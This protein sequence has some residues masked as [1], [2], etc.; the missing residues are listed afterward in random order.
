[1]ESLI[2]RAL[3][4]WEAP[5][6]ARRAALERAHADPGIPNRA[7][8]TKSF[9]M[10]DEHPTINT[11]HGGNGVSHIDVAIVGSGITGL[12]VAHTLF[13]E[14]EAGERAALS[15][16]MLEAR[17]VCSGATGR[18][19]GHLLETVAE[20][21]AF[22]K[23]FGQSE[24]MKLIRFRRGH[25]ESMEELLRPRKSLRTFS[26]FRQVEFVD[27]YFDQAA[28]QEA[29]ENIEAFMKEMPQES[30][31]FAVKTRRALAEEYG[32]SPHAVG[33]IVGPA[34]AV[35]PYRLV[36]GVLDELVRKHPSNFFIRTQA[37]VRSISRSPGSHYYTLTT[38]TGVVHAR[39]IVHCTNGHIGH[40]VPGLRGRVIPLRGQMSAQEPGRNFPSQGHR[41]SWVF[42]YANGFDY[43]TQLPGG[44]VASAEQMM[45]G[46]GLA[47]LPYQGVGEIGIAT[48]D[49]ITLA[50]DIH[51][52]GA[53]SAAFGEKNWGPTAGVESMWT[54]IMGFTPDNFPWVGQLPEGVTHR[55]ANNGPEA[56]REWAAAGFCGEGMV[57]AWG[58]GKAV[59]LMLLRREGYSTDFESWFPAQ[60]AITEDRL[61]RATLSKLSGV[62]ADNYDDMQG[63]RSY[64]LV[65]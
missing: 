41:H 11:Q 61:A 20:Y 9:W 44:D 10:K 48:D 47:S 24:A 14:A 17:D 58:S 5:A 31:G 22:K 64:S 8:S 26:Q 53:M 42:N 2:D 57:Q 40:L 39:H 43:L 1:M 28:F 23:A 55:P 4:N 12:S 46:G 52:R 25:L 3:N 60:L 59:A 37:P 34:G 16:M 56:G 32:L 21:G 35:W 63:A 36:S 51:L 45:F 33:A 27:V 15:V 49:Q 50:A 19:G 7:K 18:N 13:E 6:A 65:V 38:P 62:L 54:G 29:V 30:R